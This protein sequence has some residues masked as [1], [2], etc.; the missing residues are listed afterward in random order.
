[1]L[2]LLPVVLAG[3]EWFRRNRLRGF[4]P[5]RAAAGLPVV[6]L[7][8]EER[9]PGDSRLLVDERQQE[10][11]SDCFRSGGGGD[12]VV[13]G[14]TNVCC[15]PDERECVKTVHRLWPNEAL[16]GELAQVLPQPAHFEQAA[17]LVTE[18]M[19]AESVPCGPDV[20]KIVETLQAFADA[21]FDELYVQQI[22]DRQAEFFD[23]LKTEV[24]PA[25]GG[26]DA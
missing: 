16:P 22:G 23:V 25:L 21:G 6:T 12:K 13:Q 7:Q 17:E 3:E 26:P 8:A 10:G 20:G 2:L 19:I 14:G 18:D 9:R 5:G 11:L 4:R 1:M 24:L 15:G